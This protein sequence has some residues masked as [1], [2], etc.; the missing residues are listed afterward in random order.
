MGAALPAFCFLFGGL[1]DEVGE[2]EYVETK[3]PLE[4]LQANALYMVGAGL[5]LWCVAGS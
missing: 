5:I 4:G 2:Q 3:N 1:V